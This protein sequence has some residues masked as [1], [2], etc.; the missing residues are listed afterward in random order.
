MEVFQGGLHYSLAGLG[1]E[2]VE[3]Q[4]LLLLGKLSLPIIDCFILSLVADG[5]S[6]GTG[7]FP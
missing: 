2:S 7:F 3:L 4:L 5:T 6:T 1:E